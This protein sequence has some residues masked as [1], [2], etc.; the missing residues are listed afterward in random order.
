MIVTPGR[1]AEGI[2]TMGKPDMS[3]RGPVVGH[4]IRG[5]HEKLEAFK[6]GR[7]FKEKTWLV[8]RGT[9]STTSTADT[10]DV[11]ITSKK[12]ELSTID[13]LKD[14]VVACIECCESLFWVY[15]K[16][17]YSYACRQVPMGHGEECFT[18]ICRS[19]HAFRQ[20]CER[21]IVY[22]LL[23]YDRINCYDCFHLGQ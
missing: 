23:L 16:W 10:T 21:P 5:E 13:V 11:E 15:L 6:G 1:A 7:A 18:E 19:E 4:D 14:P 9:R 3:G 20:K 17:V 8:Q 2:G 22:T 12:I